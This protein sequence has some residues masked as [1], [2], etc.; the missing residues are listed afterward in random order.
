MRPDKFKAIGNHPFLR[1]F[2]DEWALMADAIGQLQNNAQDGISQFDRNVKPEFPIIARITGQ[3]A[4]VPS[5][6]SW[7]LEI[8]DQVT[9][10]IYDDNQQAGVTGGPGTYTDGSSML[11]AFERSGNTQVPIDGSAFVELHPA[12]TGPWFWFDWIPDPDPE[13]IL[14]SSVCLAG[15]S[16]AVAGTSTLLTSAS[17]PTNITGAVLTFTT[18]AVN[19][20]LEVVGV[21]D[22]NLVVAVSLS[23]KVYGVLSVD[24][25]AQATIAELGSPLLGSPGTTATVMQK[26]VLN[27]G[28]GTHTLQLQGYMQTVV[29]GDT[30]TA[31]ANTTLTVGPNSLAVQKRQL[32]PGGL[33]GP[34]VCYYNPADCLCPGS[35]GGGPGLVLTSC[36]P[37]GLPTVIPLNIVGGS[38]AGVYQLANAG[39]GIATHWYWTGTVAGHTLTIT[40]ACA[41][42]GCSGF[43]LLVVWNATTYFN[44]QAPDAGCNCDCLTWTGTGG[45]AGI[46][47][48][49]CQIGPGPVVN[50]CCPGGMQLVLPVSYVTAA[51]TTTGTITYDPSINAW[52]GIFPGDAD[53]A[54]AGVLIQ[55]IGGQWV[56][57]AGTGS[58]TATAFSCGNTPYLYFANV[59]TIIPCSTGTLIVGTG[60]VTPCYCP[61]GTI[62]PTVVALS[63]ISGSGTCA[64]FNGQGFNLTY[65]PT[66]GVGGVPGWTGSGTIGGVAAS[67]IFYCSGGN[68][69]LRMTGP[70]GT[71]DLGFGPAPTCVPFLWQSP[72]SCSGSGAGCFGFCSGAADTFVFQ[73]AGNSSSAGGITSTGVGTAHTASAAASATI[74]GITTNPGDVLIVVVGAS[75]AGRTL[76]NLTATYNG[77]PMESAVLQNISSFN[78]GATVVQIFTLAITQGQT[79]NVVVTNSSGATHIL[80][81]Q[82]IVDSNLPFGVVDLTAT[83]TGTGVAP[84]VAATGTTSQANEICHVAFCFVNSSAITVGTWNSPFISGGQDVLQTPGGALPAIG[85]TEGSDL[86]SVTGTPSAGLTGCTAFYWAGVMITLK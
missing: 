33:V 19:T 29:A 82:A 74:T 59:Q 47:A 54:A 21:F 38:F 73:V 57:E 65:G 36:C 39:D 44:S 55:C 70:G 48:S 11:P 72:A 12:S 24:T 75:N 79:G 32:L 78:F 85:L 3:N 45:G 6:Y 25:V 2:A 64:A 43:T 37:N 67:A 71:A 13:I 51:G 58:V 4:A 60:A 66:S 16:Q 81:A 69:A 68:F 77:L 63:V 41:G 52:R 46:V 15:S 20:N 9:T 61:A 28:P 23:N 35:G 53:C 86:L 30:A 84:A 7:T 10:G 31:S 8:E 49:N 56:L 26:W 34:P 5:A 14:V 42:S 22:F 17:T 83:N 27:L 76:A 50:T 62:L 1:Q 40:L 80:E 18:T